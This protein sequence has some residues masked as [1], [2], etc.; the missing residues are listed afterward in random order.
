MRAARRFALWCFVLTLATGGWTAAPDTRAGE[1]L[2]AGVAGEID[3]I[4]AEVLEETGVPGASIAV[5]HDG[6]IALTRAYGLARL[7]PPTAAGTAMRYP[8]GSISKQMTAATVVILADEGKLDLDDP[9]SGFFP[10]VTR[11]D[12]ITLRQLLSHTSGI[13][14]YWPQDY[15]PPAMLEPISTAELVERHATQPL[16]F[17]PGS[18]WQYSNTGYVIAG[19]IVEQVSGKSLIELLK[20]KIFEPLAMASIHDIDRSALPPG[21]PTGY[22]RFALGPLRRAPKEGQGWIFAAGQLAMTAEDLA[23]WDV[24]MIEGKLPGA[25]VFS[26]LWREVLLDSGV[27]TGYGLGVG[28]SLQDGRRLVRHGGEVS[29]FTATNLVY[30]DE[31]AAVVVFVNQ[32]ASGAHAAIGRRIADLLFHGDAPD[33]LEMRERVAEVLAG[34]RRGTIDRSLF[35]PNGNAYFSETALSDIRGSLKGLGKPKQITRLR[36][37]LRGGLT[38]RVYRAAFKKKTLEIVTRATPDGKLEQYTVSVE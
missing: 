15:V 10:D 11:S 36:Q 26:E 38:T 16:D 3:A 14:D 34:L 17:E 2:S 23:R 13:R 35:T 12:E 25:A 33:D 8:I 19:A 28:V 24:A 4:V 22:Q 21:D 31:R 6:T 32:D 7:D 5:V 20:E 27:G 29:G 18:K 1:G 30:P 37:S 9:I